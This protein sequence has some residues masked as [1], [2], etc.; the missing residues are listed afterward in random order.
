MPESKLDKEN[1]IKPIK[2]MARKKA[3]RH[4]GWGGA[5]PGAGRKPEGPTRLDSMMVIRLTQEQKDCLKTFGSSSWLRKLLQ[6]C[7]ERKAVTLE[8]GAAVFAAI[9]AILP[10]VAEEKTEVPQTREEEEKPVAAVDALLP[11][12]DEEKTEVPQKHEEEKPVTAKKPSKK[13]KSTKKKTEG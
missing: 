11:S 4:P 9:D 12:A 5:R 2:S 7:I 1:Q 3:A 8:N 10:P 13:R 6:L